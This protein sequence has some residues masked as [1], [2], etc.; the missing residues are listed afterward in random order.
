MGT[1][2]SVEASRFALTGK[3]DAGAKNAREALE[4]FGFVLEDGALDYRYDKLPSGAD[5]VNVRSLF[6][7][8]APYVRARSFVRF[9]ELDLHHTY[10]FARGK[11]S[12]RYKVDKPRPERKLPYE[13][14][15]EKRFD[16]GARAARAAL[17]ID[18]RNAGHWHTLGMCLGELGRQDE[19]ID[20]HRRAV[21]LSPGTDAYR[22][23]LIVAVINRGE[24]RKALTL[25]DRALARRQ[26]H[27]DWRTALLDLR[28]SCLNHLERHAELIATARRFGAA[29][30]DEVVGRL[31]IAHHECGHY[32]EAKKLLQRAIATDP[33]PVWEYAL[34]STLDALGDRATRA[35][36]RALVKKLG[37]TKDPEQMAMV[38][39]LRAQLG[40]RPQAIIDRAVA[41]APE[42]V[43]VQK[44]AARIALMR[45]DAAGALEAADRALALDRDDGYAHLWRAK[46]LLALGRNPGRSRTKA[47]LRSANL[48]RMWREERL[49]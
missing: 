13:L 24:Y 45:G 46:A 22:H 23:D 35:H 11:V 27:E 20:A 48:A 1:L 2:I 10:T 17:R 6:D 25:V 7:T 37:R 34:C 32:K 41:A 30:P 21:A 43:F 26:E 33:D 14:Y 28:C 19:E 39:L 12:Y 44:C 47:V 8:I 42:N 49:M 31:A 4:R 15:D 18:P 40:E 36:R 3:G 5:W 9:R 29:I 16:E 38:A